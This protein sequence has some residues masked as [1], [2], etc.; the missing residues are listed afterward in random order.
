MLLDRPGVTVN[1]PKTIDRRNFLRLAGVTAGLALAPT[2][3]VRLPNARA[4]EPLAFVDDYTTN[5]SANLTAQ[6]NAAVRILSGMAELWQTGNAWNTGTVANAKVLHA[7]MRHAA[8]ITAARTDAEAKKS[9]IYDRQHQSYAMIAGLGPL[10]GLYRTGAKAVT[11]ITSAP[12]GTPAT[13]I[14]D[15][16][17][18]GAPAGSSLGAGSVDSDLGQVALLVNTLR[19]SF[20]SGNPAKAAFQYPRPWR[21]NEDSEVV[22]TG[23]TDPLGFPVYESDVV[24]AAQLLRQRSL[25]PAS[26]GGFASG[27]T[28]AFY[29]AGLALAYAIPERFQE[30]LTRA[31]E[32]A[33]TRIIAGMHSPVD[34]IGGR[35]LATALAAATLH[36]PQYA[37][38]KQAARAQALAYFQAQTGTGALFD[39]AHS[40]GPD[41]D[42]YADREA[43]L[44][45]AEPRL[46]YDLPQ[47]GRNAEVTVPKGAEVLLETRLPY[48]SADQRREVL[49]TTALPSGYELLDGPEQWGRLNLLAAADG[50]AA[51]ASDVRVQQDAAAG[52]FSAADTWKHDIDGLGALVKLGTGSLRLT[53]DN[54]YKGGT[55]VQGG[56]LAVGSSSALGRG[57]VEVLGGTLR[58]DLHPAGGVQVQGN[59]DQAAGTVLD[60]TLRNDGVPTLTITGHSTLTTGAAL[61]IRLDGDS[62]FAVDHEVTVISARRL[63]GTFSLSTDVEGYR[64]VARY[65]ETGLFVRLVAL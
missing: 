49:R 56:V 28:N 10:A 24:V 26:D 52:G 19:G 54:D 39:Y 9:F 32:L 30:L 42:P 37:T 36:D 14:D 18:A 57:D 3:L 31:G 53:G 63:R 2:T 44:A 27:H 38:L 11:S 13:T 65:T 1:E 8:A 51:F 23:A 33:D 25:T 29:L 21:M 7:S 50:Y 45:A 12:D 4:A 5:V 41:T 47:H 58:L 62:S 46:T 60:L 34:V 6:T 55:S 48:L 61:V 16:V 15:A 59:Y 20:A 64:A 17:P 43:N 22:P 40:A 35:I